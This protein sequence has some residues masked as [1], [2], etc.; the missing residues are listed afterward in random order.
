M[1]ICSSFLLQTSSATDRRKKCDKKDYIVAQQEMREKRLRWGK[2]ATVV[3]V[4]VRKKISHSRGGYTYYRQWGG[5]SRK[6][7]TF[8]RERR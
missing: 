1:I 2:T 6:N 4:E 8:K 5:E 3:G 7:K